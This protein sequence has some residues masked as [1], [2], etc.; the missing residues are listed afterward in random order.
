VTAGSGGGSGNDGT[1]GNGPGTGGG[2]GS[3]NGTGTGTGDGAG[4]G[5]GNGT[6]YPPT[7]IQLVILPLPAPSKDKK[8]DLEAVYDVD[9]LGHATL[10]QWNKPK[11]DGYAKRV[12]QSLMGYKFRPAVR[13]DGTPTRGTAVI[14]VSLGG[15]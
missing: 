8:Y 9:S 7:P 11:D 10:V 15:K 14:R 13:A 6:I 4:T 3:G 2:K 5:G 1:A 12:L